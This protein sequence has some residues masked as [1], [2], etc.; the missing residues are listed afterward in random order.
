LIRLHSAARPP[1]V[2]CLLLVASG[3]ATTPTSSPASSEQHGQLTEMSRVDGPIVLCDHKVPE[4]VCTRHHPELVVEFKRAG[5]WCA[6]HGVP[7]SQCLI[8]HPDLTFDPLPTLKADADV[9]WLSR[10][11][12]DVPDLE[13]RA[14]KGKVTVFEFYA[15]WC[16]AC[17]KVDGHVYKRLASD[18]TT[19]AY[20]KINVVSWESPVAKRY[21][22]EVPSLPF[23]VVYGRDGKKLT[24]LHGADLDALDK[25]IAEAAT[26]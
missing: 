10:Q 18:D 8:C 3:C 2:L 1:F 5:D 13:S 16:A 9:Q 14:V 25:A 19:I 11:G 15:D 22:H 7:E 4:K 17:R 20:R 23:L 12:E 6:P 26:K 24:S 21:I